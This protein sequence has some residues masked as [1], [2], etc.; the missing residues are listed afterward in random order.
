MSEAQ[1]RVRDAR[2]RDVGRGIARIDQRTMQKLSISAGDVV[3][4]T[5]KRT[6]AAIAWPAYSEDQ[7]RGLIRIDGFTRKNAGAAMNEY[8]VIKPGKVKNSLSV[9]L[10]P[11][12]MRLN[13]DQDFTAFVKNRLNER[14]FAEGDITLVIVRHNTCYNARSSYPIRM[15]PSRLDFDHLQQLPQIWSSLRLGV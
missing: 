13:V 8:V 3:E 6:T 4:I 15:Q 12:D 14:V 7:D 5:G 9:V 2:Q 11:V 10:A 1:L